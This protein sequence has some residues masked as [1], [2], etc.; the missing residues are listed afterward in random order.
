MKKICLLLNKNNKKIGVQTFLC[1]FVTDKHLNQ[2]RTFQY[3]Q[4]YTI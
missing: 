4:L 3:G 1:K 2:E